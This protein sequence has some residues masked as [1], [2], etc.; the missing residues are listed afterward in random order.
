VRVWI[1]PPAHNEADDL[2]ALVARFRELA[3][4]AYRRVSIVDVHLLVRERFG[5]R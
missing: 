5:R 3:D 1:V 4:E 2:P